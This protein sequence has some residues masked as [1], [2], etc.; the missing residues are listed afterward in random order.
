VTDRSATLNTVIIP[1]TYV[2]SVVFHDVRTAAGTTATSAVL[3][4]GLPATGIPVDLH[5]NMQFKNGIVYISTGTPNLTF[6]WN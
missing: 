5:P 3:S 4:F 6:G 2:G 1:G